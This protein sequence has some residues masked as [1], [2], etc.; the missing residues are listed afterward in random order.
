MLNSD[1][2]G[3]VEIDSVEW[4]LHSLPK[5]ISGG[6]IPITIRGLRVYDDGG[7]RGEEVDDDKRELLLETE[8]ATGYIDAHSLMFGHHDVVIKD[9]KVPNGGYVLLRQV[10]EPYPLH[11]HYDTTV[12]SLASAFY[13]RLQLGF[14]AGLTAS[15]M[16][17]FDIRNFDVRGVT[18][19]I[20]YPGV[21]LVAENVHT[22]GFLFSDF[23]DPL[24]L[25]AYF[26]LAPRAE[27]GLLRLGDI[28]A[29]RK[30]DLAKGDISTV[31]EIP[32][33]EIQIHRLAQLP[34]N[35]PRDT[36]AHDV[37]WNITART[38]DGAM[39]HLNG[40][41]L[42][43]WVG[44]Y[45]GDFDI[46]L[47]IEQGGPLMELISNKLAGGQS[48]RLETKVTGP[49][50][51]PKVQLGVQGLDLRIPFSASEPPLDLH[52]ASAKAAFDLVTEQGS[53]E[54]TIAQGAGGEVRL[55]AT[56]GLDPFQFDVHADI[57]K[58]IVVG[59]YLPDEVRKLAGNGLHG[60]LHVFGD[61]ERQKVDTLDLWLGHAHMTGELVADREGMLHAKQLKV[62]L[63]RTEVTSNGTV[64]VIA[65]TFD[66]GVGI[67]STDL[68]RWLRP[69]DVPP[70]ATGVS[71][72]AY[73]AGTFAKPR[74]RGALK[75]SGIPI[76]RE[77]QVKL[78]Y[79]DQVVAIDEATSRALGGSMWARGRLRLGPSVR[80]LD[81]EASA[82]ELD[83]ARVPMFGGL[84]SGR[85]DATAS[86]NGPVNRLSAE[87]AT[88]F[89]ELTIAGDTYRFV[90]V[91]KPC[92][93]TGSAADKN[94][95]T[96]SWNGIRVCSYKDGSKELSFFVE[97]AGGGTLDTN[98]RIGPDGQLGGTIAMQSLPL[99]QLGVLGG[100]R[101]SPMG[102]VV[103]TALTLG[104]TPSAPTAS[105]GLDW[106]GGWFERT[107]LGAGSL[108]IR[109]LGPGLVGIEGTLLQG[110]VRVS[111]RVRTQAPYD[112]ELHVE[113]GRV[114]VDRFAPKLA[115]ELKTRGWISG[116]VDA[117]MPLLPVPG[118]KPDVTARLTE[119]EI[120]I[121]NVD[122]Q[123]R[124]SPVKIHNKPSTPLAFHFDG[125]TVRLTEKVIL[126]GPGGA[127]FELLGQG[128]AKELDVALSG[129]VAIAM[130]QPY[131]KDYFDSMSGVLATNIRVSGAVE[132]P[133]IT[134]G[135]EITEPVAVRPVGQDA[136][137]SLAQGGLIKITN[138]QI[139]P[140]AL[141]VIMEDPYT[142]ERASLKIGGGVR[143]KDFTPT[144]LGLLIE[145]ELSGKLLS[146]L[147]PEVFS[148]A[149]GVAQLNLAI[150]G[151]PRSPKP[152]GEIVFR[153]KNPLTLTPRGLRRE[154]RL[155]DG[156]ISFLG[157]D[158][159]FLAIAGSI[160]DEGLIRDI[161]GDITMENLQPVSVDV[162]VTADALP[163]RIPRTLDLTVNVNDLRIVGN[164][165]QGLDIS[166]VVEVVD[167]RYIRNFN[168][169]TEALTPERNTEPS[170]PFYESVP[171]L[172]DAALDLTLDT[173]G[174]FVQ[175]NLAN[176]QLIGQVAIS[177]TPRV[178]KVDGEIRVE[179]GLFKLP[180]IRSKFTRTRGSVSFSEYKRFPTDTPTLDLQSE[181]DYRDPSGQEHLV[182][183]TI[184]GPLSSLNWDLY[185]SSGLNK[186]QTVTMLFSGRTP[187][188]F[189][190]TLGDETPG[191]DPSRVDP[192]TSP[193]ENV[194]DQLLKDLAG[195]FI[196]LLIEDKL[197]NLTTL[198]VARLEIGT[199]SIG[200]H[201]EKEVVKSLRFLGDLEQTLR[202]RTVDVRGQYRLSDKLAV[203]GE[204][205]S[206]NFD[207]DSEEDINDVRLRAVLRYFWP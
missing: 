10:A 34:A 181:S 162:S 61:G 200:F 85:I 71:G 118:K 150:R 28:A 167:G 84:V 197:R 14:R 4:P 119:A 172:A 104:G 143:L 111:A 69:F 192:S 35:W 134:I 74:A 175:N 133:D 103:S 94:Q 78:G 179:Q 53:L 100:V 51:G 149:S 135:M 29:G 86:A 25:K 76:L 190:K 24:K 156:E 113:F 83:L 96:K 93:A 99:Q 56:F 12:V 65:G 15:T 185:T 177:G 21:H 30:G 141:H 70:V 19:E 82:K 198:D 155:S 23:S 182:T 169:I 147:A 140:T 97:R 146:V 66:L 64:D 6:W 171:L 107:F 60:R 75:F 105:G 153:T 92:S 62:R 101:T 165:E 142:G 129:D 45:G 48:L 58:P 196:S 151:D 193:S 67:S 154:I 43:Y 9:L 81:F 68:P 13:A 176:I 46:N 49:S 87:V 159:E 148:R 191:R 170:K 137:V 116:S 95:E 90:E 102:G 127:E 195:D 44:Y 52:L 160:D 180:G 37:A 168:L 26:S 5:V 115:K 178:P 110:D 138:E 73:V 47:L 188:E 17:I 31:Y 3:R 139:T 186:G 161:H 158:I 164:A 124:P 2:R 131:L 54:D 38:R 144:W 1:I 183:L 109:E 32:L 163:F 41:L 27:R 59:P 145:G 205:L 33:D 199:G 136:V 203:E 16:P 120:W 202:G 50:I 206:K 130:L 123:G 108:E 98:A 7:M 57:T 77:M 152:Y 89:Q 22:S 174:F 125:E 204:Y 91:E 88:N 20:I 121:D 55:R 173:R 122:S 40:A 36:V 112:T 79:A 132:K 18:V 63:G 184:K 128:N 126:V 166:G 157:D 80:L 187:E 194:A 72:T 106:F 207:D 8:L 201:G 11:E 117:R 114:E 42:D 189:R 39:I